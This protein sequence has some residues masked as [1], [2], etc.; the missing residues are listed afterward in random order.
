MT[1]P[2]LVLLAGAAL[3]GLSA[4]AAA[5][6]IVQPPMQRP[7]Q[8]PMQMPGQAPFQAPQNMPPCMTEFLPLRAEAEKRADV[9]KAAMQRKAPRPKLCDLFKSF[10]E[11]E[12][13]VV[14]YATSNQAQCGIPAE[15]VSQMKGNH[16]KTVQIRDR[17]CAEGVEAPKPTGPNLGEALG[18][19]VLPTPETTTTGRGTLDTLTGNALAPR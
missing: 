11:A 6:M 7:G 19:R 17:V 13:K 8:P 18:T 4:D 10:S 5:Q 12:A 15:A 1:R 16:G 14:K 3:L 9:L 2:R